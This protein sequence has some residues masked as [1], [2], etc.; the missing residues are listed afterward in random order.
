MITVVSDEIVRS[1]SGTRPL[2][3][4]IDG[5]DCAGKTTLAHELRRELLS[6]DIPV[7]LVS[8]DGFHRP[9]AERLARGSL[10]PEGYYRDSF[11]YPELVARF[12]EPAKHATSRVSVVTSLYDWKTEQIRHT[13]ADLVADAV[14]LFE[15]VFL[16]RPE[17]DQFWDFR[18]LVD[19]PLAVSLDR[20][21]A[22][23]AEHFGGPAGARERY[24]Q[25]YV[26]GQKIYMAGVE[27]RSKADVVVENADPDSPVVLFKR[28][29]WAYSAK[30]EVS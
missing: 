6:R 17:I 4:G 11:D 2:L 26:P 20:G 19:V 24:E 12:L 14:V 27:P 28:D 13:R 29:R 15:G 3:V 21:I 25:R 8:I 9:R 30:G 5:V 1:A 7:L 18:V 23:D 16:Y 22:R 10:S